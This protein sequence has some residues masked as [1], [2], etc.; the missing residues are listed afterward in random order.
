VHQDPFLRLLCLRHGKTRY[1]GVLPDLTEEGIA[2][3]RR[4]A[5]ID[6]T[7]WMR[8]NKIAPSALSIVH[9]PAARAQGTAMIIA[10]TIRHPHPIVKVEEIGPMVQRD[11]VRCE[12]VLNGFVGRGYIDYETEPDF[13]DPTLF[14]TPSEVEERRFAHLARRIEVAMKA[15]QP[16]FEVEISHY[17]VLCPITAKLFGVVS[18]AETALKYVEPIELDFFEMAKDVCYVRGRFRDLSQAA[19]FSLEDR[20]FSPV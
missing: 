1:T 9:S 10:E 20:A 7:Y 18:S 15:P 3:V 17:E 14:E 4:A 2:A 11:P 13:A 5:N 16:Q 19:A 6:V 8:R 12:K